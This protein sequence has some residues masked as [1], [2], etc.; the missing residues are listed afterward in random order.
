MNI[1]GTLERT[2]RRITL[3]LLSTNRAKAKNIDHLE[4][5]LSGASN[6]RI[7]LIRVDRIGDALI[8]TPIIR[9]IRERFSEGQ[10][11]ILLGEKN[12]AVSTLLFGID[13]S[14]VLPRSPWK[15]F[16]LFNR[17]RKN[18]YDV[19]CNLHLK[20][21]GSA[22]LVTQLISCT[23]RIDRSIIDTKSLSNDGMHIIEQT[24]LLLEPL[25]ITPLTRRDAVDYQLNI[26]TS[27]REK[28][29]VSMDFPVIGLNVS[30]AG[31]LRKWP[32][33]FYVE[34]ALRLKD[35]ELKPLMFGTPADISLT[36]RIASKA[37]VETLPPTPNFAS[38]A[39]SLSRTDLIVT[40]DT[41]VVHLG[42]ALGKPVVGLYKSET[43]MN[44]WHPWG[45][46]Y[47]SIM[48][49]KGMEHILPEQVLE[50][51]V[52]IVHNDVEF[53]KS[54]VKEGGVR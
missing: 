12:Q 8:S 38:F 9:Q 19:I 40:P 36:K 16:S 35:Q 34:L 5:T 39:N 25:G 21:S 22:D 54:S 20:P 23:Y 53:N 48:N 51:I 46:T 52:E 26:N 44:E 17:L 18:A 29:Q 32:E 2:I 33:N 31:E 10:I 45:T 47:R 3:T 4:G 50:A 27:R 7:L 13:S 49:I 6:L 1:L 37:S 43:A 24:S 28:D 41:S 15:W 30:V 42:A 11:D 14:F